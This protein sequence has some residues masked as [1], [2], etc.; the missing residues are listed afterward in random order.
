[1]AIDR[2]KGIKRLAIAVGVPWFG[3]W[4]VAGWSSY[5]ARAHYEK[6]WLEDARQEH[7]Q[8]AA[9]WARDQSTANEWII[10]SIIFGIVLPIALLIVGALAF[11]VYRGFKPRA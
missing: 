5:Q 3:F 1:M 4:A 11:W 6:L 8:S 10:R 2:R 9:I 7:W